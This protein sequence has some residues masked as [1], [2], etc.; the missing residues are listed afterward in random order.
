MPLELA[1]SGGPMGLRNHSLALWSVLRGVPPQFSV[2]R[3]TLPDRGEIQRPGAVLTGAVL[4]RTLWSPVFAYHLPDSA[5]YGP[6]VKRFL[7][8]QREG[9]PLPLSRCTEVELA[10]TLTRHSN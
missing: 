6:T 2:H 8:P 4:R 1:G 10:A 9:P 5:A 3:P 7:H